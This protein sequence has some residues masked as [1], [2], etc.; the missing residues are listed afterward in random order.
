MVTALDSGGEVEVEGRLRHVVFL[1]NRA[2][3]I[4]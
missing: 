1:Y 4:V 2:H 3:S